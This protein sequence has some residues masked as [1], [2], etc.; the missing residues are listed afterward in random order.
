VRISDGFFNPAELA[1]ILLVL[2]SAQTVLGYQKPSDIL[3][4]VDAP[5]RG[6]LR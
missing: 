4:A 6:I 5:L 1:G 2:M 3:F